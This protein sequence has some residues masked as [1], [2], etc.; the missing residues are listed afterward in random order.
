LSEILAYLADYTDKERAWKR[1]LLDYGV[2]DLATVER[3]IAEVERGVED[4]IADA[5]R[6]KEP[7]TLSAAAL[8]NAAGDVFA[9]FP[10]RLPAKRRLRVCLL[11]REYPPLGH[12]GIGQWTREVATGLAARGHEV[13]VIA[14]A[15]DGRPNIDFIDGVWVHR[16]DVSP[17]TEAQVQAFAPAPASLTAYSL[18]LHQEYERIDG[19]RRFDLISG[20]IADLEPMACL[21]RARIPVIVSLHTTYKLSLPHKPDWL[22]RPDYLSRHVEPAILCEGRLIAEGRHILANSHAILDDIEAAHGLTIDRAKVTIVPHGI[23]DVAAIAPARA[24]SDDAVNLLFVGRLEARKGADALLAILPDLLS[25]HPALVA[26]IVGEDNIPV[27]DKTLRQTFLDDNAHR[28]EVLARMRFHGV[29][30][31]ADVEARYA[32]ADIFVAPS[33][34]ESF[35]LIFIEAMCFGKPV[36]AYDVGGASEI[37]THGV[38]G[39]LVPAGEPQKLADAIARL[40]EDGA[41]REQIG[42][43]ARKT[44]EAR[45]AKA[46]MIDRL[47]AYYRAVLAEASGVSEMAAAK[48][49][50]S[51]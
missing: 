43:A 30:P 42:A 38:D 19:H 50:R 6:L 16:I 41:L 21:A 18:A 27:G 47:E 15:L 26:D 51:A 23:A 8:A 11:S 14:R 25:A 29:L 39:F 36:V 9:P 4:G 31:R 45:Y 7:A 22:S 13:T 3:L 1:S 20:P 10:Q 12:G 34:Y 2:A 24:R 46:L 17:I 28:P 5:L 33:K 32:A 48:A 40:A 49:S 44:Y 37:I 35:G